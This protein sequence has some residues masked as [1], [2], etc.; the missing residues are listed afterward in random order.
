M[1]RTALAL[2]SLILLTFFSLSLPITYSETAYATLTVGTFT[3]ITLSA[4][5]ISNIT[6]PV[7]NVNTL[8]TAI[9]NGD[10]STTYSIYN[11]TFNGNV[12]GNV[13]YSATDFTGAGTIGKGNFSMNTTVN[14]YASAD[15]T[16]NMTFDTNHIFGF[17][18]NADVLHSNFWVYVPDAGTAQGYYQS[19]VTISVAQA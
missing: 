8:A 9:G 2:S 4:G 16:K 14:D 17:L 19:I 6:F 3:S 12:Q 18:D 15:F 13:T 11:V 7:S 1:K 5:Y 10:G